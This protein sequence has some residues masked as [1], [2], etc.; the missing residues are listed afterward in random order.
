MSLNIEQISA[1]LTAQPELKNALIGSLKNDVLEVLKGEGIVIR[2]KD[3]ETEYLSNYEKNIIPGKVEAEIG[4][5]VRAIHDKYDDNLFELTGE[6]KES[7]EKTYD[8][9]K[10]KINELKASKSKGNDDPVLADQ[11]KQLQDK[12]K[13]RESYVAPD[14]VEKLKTKFFNEHVG[15]RLGGS[16]EKNAIAIPAHITDEK[17]KNNYIE[18]QRR[19]IKNDFLTRFTAKHDDAGNVVYYEGDKLL[20]DPKTAAPLTEEKILAQH[21]AGYFVPEKPAVGGA[22][23]GKGEK[24]LDQNEANLKTKEDVINYLTKKLEPQGIKQGNAEFL[25]EYQRIIKDYGITQ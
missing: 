7:H 12:L 21:Y 3:E 24:V 17:A 18:T 9:L 23:S 15:L 20:T 25:K 1:E 22:G 8:F 19:F 11:I 6:R 4:P 14:E 16:L 10:R 2:T 5:K 13:E